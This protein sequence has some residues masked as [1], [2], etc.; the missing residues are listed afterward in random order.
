MNDKGQVARKLAQLHY[1]AEPGMHKIFLLR[2][3]TDDNPH[4]PIKLLE[5][6]EATVAAGILPLQFGPH[7]ASGIDYAS[8]IVE[9][10]PDEFEQ[11]ER[12]ELSLPHGW[13]VGEFLPPTVSVEASSS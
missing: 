5:V 4:E 2:G 6:N 11:I 1:N 12:G 8:V 10:T 3:P 9:V 13:A 7:H